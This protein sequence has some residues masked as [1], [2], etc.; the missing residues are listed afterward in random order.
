MTV[1]CYKKIDKTVCL[2]TQFRVA[3]EKKQKS[4][5]DIASETRLPLKYVTAIEAGDFQAL[6]KAKAHRFAY[7]KEFALAVD[8]SPEACLA[9]L[10]CE[11]GLDG[12]HTKHPSHGV[13]LFPFASISIFVRNSAAIALTSLFVVYLMWQVKGIVEPP[14][15]A[16]YAPEEGLVYNQPAVT[17]QGETEK[18]TRLTVNGQDIMVNEQGHFETKVDLTTGLNTITILATKKHGKTTAITRHIVVKQNATAANG[19]KMP[20]Q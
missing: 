12:V 4:L 19:E 6:P 16:V 15:L 20:I 11:D 14:F 3:R 17:L 1:F 5:S 10:T 8:L 13:R 2:G 18:E 9:Q 7:I